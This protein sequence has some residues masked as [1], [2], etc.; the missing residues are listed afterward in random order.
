MTVRKEIRCS[1]KGRGVAET[2]PGK[3]EEAFAARGNAL[4]RHV[5]ETGEISEPLSAEAEFEMTSAIKQALA[6]AVEA[7]KAG[8]PAAER[9]REWV[10]PKRPSKKALKIAAM[11][12]TLLK[13][14]P[15]GLSDEKLVEHI[16]DTAKNSLGLAMIEWHDPQAYRIAERFIHA[17]L[18]LVISIARRY[19]RHGRMA[20]EDLVQEGNCGLIVAV[21]RYD[22]G[23]GLRF[24]TYG[25]WWI[26]HVIGRAMSDKGRTIRLPAGMIEF[27]MQASR[28]RKDLILGLG[29][30]PTEEELAG[31]LK[32][33]VEKLR[34]L[35]GA[36]RE[37]KSLDALLD[38]H[39]DDGRDYCSGFDYSLGSMLAGEPEDVSEWAT[40]VPDKKLRIVRS[41]IEELKPIERDILRL[42]FS[43]GE[44]EDELTLREIGEKCGLSAE[45]IRQLH[46]RL[47]ERLRQRLAR[48]FAAA[49]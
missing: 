12:A 30:L 18:R 31:A 24:S 45:R 15:S 3:S 9:Y 11:R 29:R 40:L 16:D 14:N 22:P 7:L 5:R 32:C 20:L 46:D 47:I 37:P 26:R 36:L 19:S 35:R 10:P 8:L 1:V 41:A 43:L 13:F 34:L 48:R 49:I 23:R 6:S 33:G 27:S 21:L 38:S 39:R 17:N 2:G 44:E 25:S 28:T 42:R 4:S